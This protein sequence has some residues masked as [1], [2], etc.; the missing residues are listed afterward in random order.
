DAIAV[1]HAPYTYEEK[2][3]AFAE[4]PPGAIG[5]ELAL[6]L[7]W[8]RFVE[9]GEWTAVELWRRLSSEPQ[10]CLGLPPV[11]CTVGEKAELVLF[12]P[13]RAQTVEHSTLCSLSTNTPWLNQTIQGSIL[14]TWLA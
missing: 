7:L 3:V 13:R 4:A 8:H 11:R 12:D 1:D 9:T 14:R 10:R 5:L 6:P 2:T